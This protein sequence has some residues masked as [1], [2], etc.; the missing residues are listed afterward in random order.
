MLLE[1]HHSRVV[2]LLAAAAIGGCGT[3][4][5]SSD[6][7]ARADDAGA[8][9]L[10]GEVAAS[11]PPVERDEGGTDPVRLAAVPT[12]AG[13]TCTSAGEQSVVVRFDVRRSSDAKSGKR[14]TASLSIPALGFT[15]TIFQS[16]SPNVCSSVVDTAG[17]R[18]RLRCVGDLTETRGE[19]VREDAGIRLRV[20]SGYFG[21]MARKDEKGW[22]LEEKLVVTRCGAKVRFEPHSLSDW[23]QQPHIERPEFF[24]GLEEI[25]SHG[26]SY[27]PPAAP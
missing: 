24:M 10:T 14:M 1:N 26:V 3:R 13:P 15:D 17:A 21:L 25:E 19:V 6:P 22:S 20:T 4:C 7:A 8:P 9:S 27:T 5:G 12:E 2:A 18:L 16:P 23:A 11:N